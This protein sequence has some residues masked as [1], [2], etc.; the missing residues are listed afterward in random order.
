MRARTPKTMLPLMLAASIMVSPL[1]G[2]TYN[3]S[4]PTVHERL[5]SFCAR[6]L[7]EDLWYYSVADGVL[8]DTGR[9][10]TYLH[11]YPDK[12]RIFNLLNQYEE[13]IEY[14]F[15]SADHGLFG[16]HAWQPVSKAIPSEGDV[17][18]MMLSSLFIQRFHPEGRFRSR[19]ISLYGIVEYSLKPEGYA[20]FREDI[21]GLEAYAHTWSKKMT[22]LLKSSASLEEILKQGSD[23]YI[24]LSLLA[25]ES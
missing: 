12:E 24:A 7:N 16:T 22:E 14:H 8:H 2:A 17:N 23:E 18:N 21:D 4:I 6:G 5:Q 19:V 10:G 9:S 13:L 25:D 1:S 20:R 11:V 3:A 15:H